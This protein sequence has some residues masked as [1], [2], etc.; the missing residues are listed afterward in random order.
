MKYDEKNSKSGRNFPGVTNSTKK[1]KE[2]KT[3][4]NGSV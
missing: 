4:L 3:N 1:K 2:N